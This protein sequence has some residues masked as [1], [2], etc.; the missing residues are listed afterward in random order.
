MSVYTHTQEHSSRQGIDS[1]V[2]TSEINYGST[3]DYTMAIGNE[4][5][6]MVRE[7]DALEEEDK[8]PSG[9]Y[10]WVVVLIGFLSQFIGIGISVAW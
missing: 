8:D 1:A 6:R 9:V 4:E 7:A 5:K 10:I 2:D 3:D